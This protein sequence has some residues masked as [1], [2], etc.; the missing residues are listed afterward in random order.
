MIGEILRKSTAL[1]IIAL[2]VVISFFP[3]I[4][5]TIET[6]T[7]Y[8][9]KIIYSGGESCQE[10]SDFFVGRGFEGIAWDGEYLWLAKSN[11]KEIYK[12]DQNSLDVYDSFSSPGSFPT[13]LAWDGEYL[14]NADWDTDRIY[15]IYPSNG[16]IVYSYA[17]PA[18]DPYGLA[19]DGGYLWHSDMGTQKIYK[20]SESESFHNLNI[21]CYFSTPG[22]DP[23]G[24]AWDGKYLWNADR[25][26]DQIYSLDPFKGLAPVCSFDT[27]GSAPRGLAWDGEDMWHTDLN[28]GLSKINVSCEPPNTPCRPNGP[29]TGFPKVEY[30]YTTST[31]DPGGDDVKYGWDWDG[32]YQVDDWTDNYSSGEVCVISHSWDFVGTYYVRVIAMDTDRGKSDWSYSLIMNIINRSDLDCTGKLNWHRLKPNSTVQDNF[33]IINIGGKDSK[34]DW[35]ILSYPDWGTWTF[36]PKNGSDLKPS[37]DPVKVEVVLV[38]PNQKFKK[39]SGE[40]IV[41]N[42]ED[43]NDICKI[44][45]SLT[46]P[47]NKINNLQDLFYRFLEDHPNLF[48]MF[49]LIIQ[50]FHLSLA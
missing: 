43:T 18:D 17:S 20:L 15:K 25:K 39:F 27:P 9:N 1:G 42:E 47:K 10:N 6:K 4:A 33:T 31:T 16:S 34:L 11:T 30:T 21:V 19:W 3:S 50:Y 46:T 14:W 48:P 41:I 35:K 28:E 32:D 29:E 13:G 26:E 45:V 7:E 44:P 5:D 40:I 23:T 12:L 8:T 36:T 24:L 49:R 2:F 37:D 38:V 22:V